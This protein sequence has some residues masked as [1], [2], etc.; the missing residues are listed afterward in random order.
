MGTV[1]HDTRPRRQ[2][3]WYIDLRRNRRNAAQGGARAT[4]RKEAPAILRR[5]ESEHAQ[6][7]ALGLK[8]ADFAIMPVIWK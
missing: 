6:A 4:T 3:T 8:T 7:E 5:D 2:Q 1:Y